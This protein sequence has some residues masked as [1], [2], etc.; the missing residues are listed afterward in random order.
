M[1]S[2]IFIFTAIVLLASCKKDVAKPVDPVTPGVDKLKAS[3]SF[4]WSTTSTIQISVKGT[5]VTGDVIR[6]FSIELADG[7]KAFD[8]AFN[9]KNDYTFSLTLP[10]NA[11]KIIYKYGTI[12]KEASITGNS[13]ELNYLINTDNGYLPD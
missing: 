13:L 2:L 12:T 6:K 4:D 8:A 9:M 3:Q 7:S 11:D 10:K 5:P 1:K